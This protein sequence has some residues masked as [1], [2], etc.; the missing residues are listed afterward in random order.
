MKHSHINKSEES[1]GGWVKK[2]KGMKE[3]KL[4]VIKISHR[5]VEHG[6]GNIARNIVITIPGARWVPDLP[7]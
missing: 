5:N 6:V 7:R 3:P 4:P 1:G 2:V